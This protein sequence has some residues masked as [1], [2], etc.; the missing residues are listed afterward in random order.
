M[1]CSSTAGKSRSQRPDGLN[2]YVRENGAAL[3]HGPGGSANG[4]VALPNGV[5][6]DVIF[7]GD[8]MSRE[9]GAVAP[10][11]AIAHGPDPLRAAMIARDSDLSSQNRISMAV[12]YMIA[13]PSAK[14]SRLALDSQVPPA[15]CAVRCR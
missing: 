1:P 2:A 3:W 8:G 14:P 6:C 4:A 13:R 7:Q 9:L 15:R 5:A 10:E 11:R 12:A